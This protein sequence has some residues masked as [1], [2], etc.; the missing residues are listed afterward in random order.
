VDI[1]A[2]TLNLD[3]MLVEEAITDKSKA[4]WPV[5][6]AGV[7]CNMDYLLAVAEKYSL[8]VVEDAAQGVNAFYDG[9][10]LGS[11]GHLGAYSFH[12]TKNYICGEGGALCINDPQLVER[13]EIIRDKGT[14]RQKFFRGEVDKYTW[15]EIGSS[16]VPSEIA[17]AFLYGQLEMLQTISQRRLQIC[18]FYRHHFE[19]LEADGLLQLPFVPE[20]CTSNHH[21]FYV[22]VKDAETRD[23]LLTHLKSR[24]INAV[25]HYVPLH[26]SP[27]GRKLQL[28]KGELP[29]TDQVS[30]RLL[31]LPVFYGITEDEQMQVVR[32]TADYLKMR[33]TRY[34]VAVPRNV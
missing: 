2:D 16:Y 24:G 8:R 15:V 12:E 22:I 34:K 25:F 31:R 4:I 6:Y 1:H 18:K 19:P 17:C 13:A 33:A 27:M 29:V 11:I 7:G 23:G 32:A 28:Q 20:E 14:N 5:H 9:R 21:M 3:E 26:S 10:A 30:A